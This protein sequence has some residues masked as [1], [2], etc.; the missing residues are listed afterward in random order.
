MTKKQRGNLP[1]RNIHPS[2]WTDPEIFELNDLQFRFFI[3]A[4]SS[5]QA[6]ATSM[7]IYEIHRGAMQ[8]FF[9]D[10]SLKKIDEVIKFFNKKQKMITYNAEHHIIFCKNFLKYQGDYLNSW[11]AFI[12]K[13]LHDWKKTKNKVPE[14]WNEFYKINEDRILKINFMAKN[15]KENKNKLNLD[16]FILEMQKMA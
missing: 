11:K 15:D 1:Y 16:D 13:L 5:P 14:F 2:I 9:K 10:A 6:A 7:G 4:F 3:F 12:P 8:M